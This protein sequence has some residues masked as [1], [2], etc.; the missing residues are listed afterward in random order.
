MK[1]NLFFSKNGIVAFCQQ[2]MFFNRKYYFKSG[3]I[4]RQLHY[5]M[6]RES[7]YRSIKDRCQFSIMH[8]P[9]GIFRWQKNMKS[10]NPTF[11]KK[12]K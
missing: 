1:P 7:I 12:G 9:A 8:K 11:I 5:C 3:G 10:L 6:D 4:S 2:S